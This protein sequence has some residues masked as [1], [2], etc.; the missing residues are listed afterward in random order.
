MAHTGIRPKCRIEFPLPLIRP[1]EV[2][3][4]NDIHRQ[5][6]LRLMLTRHLQHL[7]LG[8]IPQL[9]LPKAQPVLRHLRRLPHHIRIRAHDLSRRI[10]QHDPVVQDAG[11]VR[12]KSRQVPTEHSAPH[13]RV[14]P[15]EPV[16]ARGHRER[17]RRLGVALRELHVSS[18]EVEERLLVLSH[19]VN[20]LFFFF[21]LFFSFIIFVC[22]GRLEPR[23]QMPGV[24]A[25]P[26]AEL[27]PFDPQRAGLGILHIDA[28]AHELLE[29]EL[30]CLVVFYS[31]L[32]APRDC[33]CCA[34]IAD[35]RRL[36]VAI[37]IIIIRYCDGDVFVV[38]RGQRFC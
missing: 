35:V 23:R 13:R 30:P 31:E 11:R 15:Q 37:I 3:N 5:T 12:L 18:L 16:P 26:A 10:A 38:E 25:R 24:G 19:A 28:R 27:A 6:T 14:V 2:I 9:A 21:F 7:L 36:L 32:A 8:L 20:P 33:C 34:A 22:R 1:V 17:D 4:H 29:D